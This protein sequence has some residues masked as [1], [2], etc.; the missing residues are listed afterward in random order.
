MFCAN[1]K[2]PYLCIYTCKCDLLPSRYIAAHKNS[3]FTRLCVAGR[4]GSRLVSV[5]SMG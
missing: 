4:I 1:R 5:T 3:I 2:H